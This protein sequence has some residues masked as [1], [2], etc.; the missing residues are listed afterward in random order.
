M[1]HAMKERRRASGQVLVF[2]ALIL[3]LVLLPVAAYAVDASVASSAY[4]QL[5]EVAALAAEDASQ[6]V[7]VSALRLSD[8]IVLDHAQAVAVARAELAGAGAVVESV[9]VEGR[10]V[11]VT[12]SRVVKLPLDF[13][14]DGSVALK[15]SATARIAPGYASPSSRLPL[16]VNNF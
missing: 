7:D 12:A 14:G 13:V 5:I 2:F 9:D 6:Q 16:P 3:P 15:A 10:L 11:R 8:A 1:A 4:S